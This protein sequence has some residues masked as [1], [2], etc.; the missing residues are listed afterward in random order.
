[1]DARPLASLGG[2]ELAAIAS[3]WKR[4]RRE[5]S[6]SF[7]GTSMLPT[8]PP[9]TALQI[10]C[11]DD[12]RPDDIVF[13]L[14]RGQPVVHRLL[15]F[16]S[17]GRWMLTRGDAN[18]VPD[19]PIERD[20]LIGRVTTVAGVSPAPFMERTAQT[21]ARRA[22]DSA[23][24]VGVAPAR[25]LVHATWRMWGTNAKAESAWKLYGALGFLARVWSHT[26][27][28]LVD[29][30]VVY[31]GRF[32]PPVSFVPVNGYRYKRVRTGSP[33]FVEA[34][35]VLRVDEAGRRHNEA[36]VAVDETDG[37]VAACTF[38]D[39][40]DGPV[41]FNRGV[42]TDP[43]HRGKGLSG[44]VMLF[45]AWSQAPEG[46]REV[47]YHVAATNRGARRMNRRIGAREVDRWVI[48]VLLRRF[49]FARRF[50]FASARQPNP[51]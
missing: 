48:L 6:T 19:L 41:G 18:A 23:L 46:A 8:I 31:T 21:V 25:W 45:Q 29:V 49:R 5:L 9:G 26:L 3:I 42:A 11:G 28:M 17:D 22:V 43:R 30:D 39:P 40:V 4:E 44:S 7:S 38:S 15:S 24:S 27:G 33:L 2:A 13:F 32:P 1:M 35:R 47:E 34:A 14:H 16:S 36:F 12:A 51:S 37:H 50:V 10:A 20:A